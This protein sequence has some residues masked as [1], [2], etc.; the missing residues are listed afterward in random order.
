MLFYPIDEDDIVQ[1]LFL[2]EK[3]A[4]QNI[5]YNQNEANGCYIIFDL[6]VL[7]IKVNEICL[8]P[9]LSIS[10]LSGYLGGMIH[11]SFVLFKGG[12]GWGFESKRISII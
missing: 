11:R 12:G 5:F 3:L 8:K 2:K 1:Y 6:F 4:Q 10:Y 9:S 7:S